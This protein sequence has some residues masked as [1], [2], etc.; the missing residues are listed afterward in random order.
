M[1]MIRFKER[2]SIQQVLDIL[3]QMEFKTVDHEVIPINEACG[4]ILAED[5]IAK[6]DIPHF[7]RSAVDGYAVRAE[8]TFGA[9]AMNPIVLKLVGEVEVGEKPCKLNEGEAVRVSTGS[10]LPIG[11]NAVVMLEYAK[12]FNG[13]VEIY[14]AVT[15]FENVSRKGEDVKVGEVVLRRGEVLQPQDIGILASLGYSKIKVLKKPKVAIIVTGN[16]LVEVGEKV[17]VGKIINSNGPM[18]C[19]A[20]KEFNCEPIY[21]GIAKDDENEIAK[22]IEIGVK[23]ADIVLITG[24]SSVGKKDM[25]PNVVNKLGKVIVHGVAMKPGMPTGFGIIDGKPILLLPGFPVAALISFYTFFPE[26][27]AK[28]VGIKIIKKK[29]SSVKVTLTRSI[30]SQPGVRTFARVIIEDDKA[31]PIRTS[32]SGILTSMIKAN[33]IV[34][35]PEEIE[36]FE[37]GKEV[38][39]VLIR[40][41]IKKL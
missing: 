15:P 20:V 39:A 31:E 21:L 8:D 12:E 40:D 11:A 34:I 9:S 36:G 18:L 10:A 13:Y 2:L 27:L 5:I 28:I 26:I 41:I 25:V 17:E 7:D 29:W 23:Q 32:G 33:G 35:V 1:S 3:E 4:R 16:E 38:E 30:P 22:K 37:S 19:C 24:G 6:M 14:K